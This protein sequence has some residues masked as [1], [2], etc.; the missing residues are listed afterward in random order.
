ML[1]CLHFLPT[2]TI[3]S[4]NLQWAHPHPREVL[5]LTNLGRLSKDE[6]QRR[7]TAKG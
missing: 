2:P 6:E 4:A 3:V 5:I 7:D 1:H